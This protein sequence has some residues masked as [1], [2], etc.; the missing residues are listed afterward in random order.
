MP[1]TTDYAKGPIDFVGSIESGIQHEWEAMG[2]QLASGLTFSA[3]AYG[4]YHGRSKEAWRNE[5]VILWWAWVYIEFLQ[6]LFIKASSCGSQYGTAA[7][8]FDD[9]DYALSNAGAGTYWSGDAAAAY[10]D[11]NDQQRARAQ[12]MSSLDTEI[13]A[14]LAKESDQVDRNYQSLAD[15]RTTIQGFIILCMSLNASGHPVASL[16]IQKTVAALAYSSGAAIALWMINESAQNS[17]EIKMRI[18]EYRAVGA[19]AA[20]SLAELTGAAAGADAATAITSAVSEFAGLADVSPFDDL[21]PITGGAIASAVG[22]SGL[23]QQ[24]ARTLPATTDS[25][26]EREIPEDALT[27]EASA[28]EG[29]AVSEAEAA[30]T[31]PA[32]ALGSQGY[33]RAT[34]SSLG[35]A[36]QIGGALAGRTAEALGQ[37]RSTAPSGSATGVGSEQNSAGETAVEADAVTPDDAGAATGTLYAERAPIDARAGGA[38]WTTSSRS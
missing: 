16:N 6:M 7:G 2:Q 18:D 29:E 20:T 15:I 22:S 33:M 1:Q 26:A 12:K 37:A 27:A 34:K 10:N 19:G 25:A 31:L 14:V 5:V 21:R 4:R 30:Y 13:A 38:N 24:F 8:R 11:Q 9:A 23:E 35:A 28:S 32:L 17:T 3:Y 36:M